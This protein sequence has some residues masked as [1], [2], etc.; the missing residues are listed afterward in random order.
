MSS[1]PMKCFSSD[2]TSLSRSLCAECCECVSSRFRFNEESR[3]F[4]PLCRPYFYHRSAF[5]LVETN[6]NRTTAEP[7]TTNHNQKKILEILNNKIETMLA[8]DNIER[9][10]VRQRQHNDNCSCQSFWHAALNFFPL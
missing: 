8:Q 7:A 5:N 4:L 10:K 6:T 3:S 1:H 2:P 9:K